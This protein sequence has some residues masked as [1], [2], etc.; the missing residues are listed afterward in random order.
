MAVNRDDE[1]FWED[2]TD[3]E[4]SAHLDAASTNGHS[5]PVHI[6]QEDGVFAKVEDGAEDTYILTSNRRGLKLR[7]AQGSTASLDT[8]DDTDEVG[9]N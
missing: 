6:G 9:Q 2:Q 7:N 4:N 1:S 5:V 8:L 3:R